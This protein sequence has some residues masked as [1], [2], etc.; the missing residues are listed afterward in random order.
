MCFVTEGREEETK[1]E[2]KTEKRGKRD[3]WRAEREGER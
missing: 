2:E 1:M 3:K